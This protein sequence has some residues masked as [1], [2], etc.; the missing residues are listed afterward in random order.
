MKK[1]RD[2][3]RLSILL[4]RLYLYKKGTID[5][6]ELTQNIN[7]L[8]SSMEGFSKEWYWEFK[9]LWGYLEAIYYSAASH[10]LMRGEYIEEDIVE[11]NEKI[12]KMID[13]VILELSKLDLHQCPACGYDTS[14]SELW[15]TPLLKYDFCDCCG[16]KYGREPS[17][18]NEVQKYR[19]AWLQHPTLWHNPKALPENWKI[20]EQMEHIPSDYI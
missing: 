3:K 8:T 2:L 10:G 11:I 18:K 1:Q 15:T 19:D 4:E 14:D 5:L 16:L 12:Q 7:A 17:S 20:E 13:V 6:L 9:K